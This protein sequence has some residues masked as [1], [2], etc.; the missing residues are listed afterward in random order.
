MSIDT[1][2]RVAL[3]AA[4]AADLA[5]MPRFRAIDLAVEHKDD[6]TPVSEADRAAEVAIRR[7]LEGVFPGDAVLGEEYG[8]SGIWAGRRWIIDPI[9][10]T[11][12]YVRGV[13]VWAT[14]IALEDDDGI[15]VGVVSA[16]AL[17]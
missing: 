14:L 17:G 16:P 8:S 11:V 10:A 13:P 12:N 6:L 7:H 2:L 1:D 9:D 3:E 4:D 5:T 15:A